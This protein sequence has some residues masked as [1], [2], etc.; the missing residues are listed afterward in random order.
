MSP[1]AR[2]WTLWV[3]A[4]RVCPGAARRVSAGA[5]G[6]GDAAHPAARRRG[7][8]IRAFGNFVVAGNLVVG[9]VIFLIL[10]MIQFIVI[11]KGSER[12]AEVGRPHRS[13]RHC[14][15]TADSHG[16]P[17][18]CAS[19]S[20]RCDGHRLTFSDGAPISVGGT[21]D[22]RVVGWRSTRRGGGSSIPGGCGLLREILH[23]TGRSPARA[24]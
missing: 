17:S 6:V 8:G 5:G 13:Q 15:E 21:N 20:R 2:R 4:I 22:P 9:A 1:D 14:P 7:R 24:L 19:A 18:L 10:T 16:C 12:V 11:S 3:R 23:G